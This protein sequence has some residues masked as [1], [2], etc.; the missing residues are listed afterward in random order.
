LYLGPLPLSYEGI[1]FKDDDWIECYPDA[2]E[3]ID[4]NAPAP[5]VV[6]VP[7]T[8]FNDEVSFFLRELG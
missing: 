7:F 1:D 8:V 3:Y 5:K 4:N 6:T 2:K